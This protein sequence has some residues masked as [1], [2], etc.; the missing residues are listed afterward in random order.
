M[1][2]LTRHRRLLAGPFALIAL[3]I[4]AGSIFFM[5]GP[6]AQG[7][8][9]LVST[10]PADIRAGELL[11]QAS[12]QSCHGFQGKGGQTS[13][14]PLVSAGA[15]AA[16]FYL[17]TGRMPLNNP[18]NQPIRHRPYF[19][20][21]QIRQ[22]VA[23][24]NILPL[25]TGSPPGPT[26]PTVGPACPTAEPAPGC[27]T[28]SEGERAFAINCAQCHHAA[29][30]GGILSKGNVV[31]SLRNANLTQVAEAIRVGP[32]PMPVFGPAQMSDQEMSAIAHYVQYLHHPSDPGGLGLGHFGPVAEGFVGVVIG[33]SLLWF[34]TR[35]IG[36]RG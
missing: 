34:A 24:I 3:A 28:L 23:Y 27:S 32:R 17:T 35:M 6:R 29:G 19:T 13:A 30:A 33:F 20:P 1:T 10:N 9:N 25:V 16:D 15:A 21:L 12:C 14:P 18:A 11:Y 31:P 2:V 26:I 8:S 7:Q 5:V 36:T 4:V 22:L